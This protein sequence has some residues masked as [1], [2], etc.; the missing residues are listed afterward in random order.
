MADLFTT[1][2]RLD[3]ARLAADPVADA[4]I[5]QVLDQGDGETWEVSSLFRE[6][7][8]NDSPVPDSL[9]QACK[10][11]FTS[12]DQL[13]PWADMQ[14]IKQGAA[15]F[16]AVGPDIVLLL[17]CKA[18][19]MAYSC[20]KGA[21]VLV[22]T[23]RLSARFGKPEAEEFEVLNRR[24]METAQFI[25]NVMEPDG[26][27]DNGRA[28][29]TAQ[30]IRLI[31]AAIRYYLH[32]QDWDTG[33]YGEPINQEDLAGTLMSFSWAMIEG[34]DQLGVGVSREEQ[35]AYF[36]TWRVI[37]WLMGLDHDLIPDD[38]DQG[39][40]LTEQ[41]LARQSAPSAAG[42]SLTRSL[43]AY[44]A[45]LI[46][47]KFMDHLPPILIRELIGDS[48]ADMIGVTHHASWWNKFLR[49]L[50]RLLLDDLGDMEKDFTPFRRLFSRFGRVLLQ[51][52]VV[53]H[54]DYKAVRFYIPPSLQTD[55]D[56]A[57]E[58]SK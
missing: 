20:A 34:L 30:K 10:D 53:A 25:L 27:S 16:N 26:F 14:K 24:M 47:G 13:P 43:T 42:K 29:R 46:P 41:I 21:E 28:I 32:E 6:M 57:R 51:T 49:W 1:N 37:G 8:C 18:L 54:N 36:H 19:P 4:V 3:Q 7:I 38:V 50:M 39:R 55:W 17:F 9:P 12:T 45:S 31:H 33:T 56:L 40:A 11:Y 15:M 44:L 58:P 35:D 22:K 5:K 2:E 52:L 48:M 23:G